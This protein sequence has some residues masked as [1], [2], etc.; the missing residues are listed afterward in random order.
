MPDTCF[1]CGR[2]ERGGAL[3]SMRHSRD[4]D[5]KA[6]QVRG[7]RA[8]TAPHNEY[9]INCSLPF[10]PKL[11]KKSPTSSP[12]RGR[13]PSPG[14]RWPGALIGSLTKLRQRRQPLDPN[15][16][17][18]GE[19]EMTVAQKEVVPDEILPYHER[20]RNTWSRPVRWKGK[21][22]Q[23]MLADKEASELAASENMA[24]L[25]GAMLEGG[26]PGANKEL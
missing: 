24:S 26:I 22:A 16:K 10:K 14:R 21:A 23:A 4:G 19:E 7:V 25:W 8:Q 6:G 18:F 2:V 12:R 9:Y 15:K 20:N 1:K 11:T 17:P 3:Y 13:S 5:F